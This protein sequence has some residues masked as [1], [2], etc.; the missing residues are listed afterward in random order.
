M[1]RAVSDKHWIIR[2]LETGSTNKDAM[3]LA[4]SGEPLPLWVVAES[5]TQGRGRA[6]RN[7]VSSSGNLHASLAFACAAPPAVAGQI[8]LVA[9]LAFYD[10][11]TANTQPEL[12]ERLRLK[13]PNDLMVGTAKL[14]GILVESTLTTAGGLMVVAGFGLNIKS[15]PE[16]DRPVTSL[17]LQGLTCDKENILAALTDSCHSWLQLWDEGRAFSAIRECWL[18]RAGPPGQSITITAGGESLSGTYEGLN[19]T[20]A[21]LATVSGQLQT[22]NFGDVALVGSTP[23]RPLE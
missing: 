9:G 2:L 20:G 3:R 4:L 14:G 16:L 11:V 22:F 12:Q 8:A 17:S 1:S 5:Q 18:A 13:W 23:G 21:L 7:W 19:E 10:C 6:G 15:A